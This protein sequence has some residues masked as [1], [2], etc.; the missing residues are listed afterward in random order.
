[1][2]L[3]SL[4]AEYLSI[5]K[6]YYARVELNIAGQPLINEDY[7]ARIEQNIAEQLLIT[8]VDQ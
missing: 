3:V 4:V 1:L 5:N 8:T 2:T 7:Y 6:D